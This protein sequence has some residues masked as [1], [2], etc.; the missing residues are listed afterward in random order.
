M[1]K[2]LT[3][4]DKAGRTG[5]VGGTGKV[6]PDPRQPIMDSTD[7]SIRGKAKSNGWLGFLSKDKPPPRDDL[8]V[9]NEDDDDY[10]SNDGF[11]EAK[12]S[13]KSLSLMALINGKR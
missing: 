9:E 10:D 4:K 3:G 2:R 1:K 5:K 6:R 8:E 7:E 13:K 11:E 12:K